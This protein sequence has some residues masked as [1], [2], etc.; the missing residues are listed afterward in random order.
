MPEKY[1]H[2]QNINICFVVP[3]AYPLIVSEKSIGQVGGAEVQQTIIAKELAK[4]GYNVSMVCLDY[5]QNDNLYIDGIRIVKAFR[6]DEGVPVLRY[7]YPRATSIWKAMKACSADIYYQRSA[8]ML[9]GLVALFCKRYKRYFLYAAAHDTDF[10]QGEE[11]IQYSR[12][13]LIYRWGLRYADAIIVQNETQRQLSQ[14]LIKKPIHLCRNLYPLPKEKKIPSEEGYILWVSTIREWKR[15]EL[16]LEIATRLPNLQFVMIGGPS[17][18]TSIFA[19]IQQAASRLSNVVFKGFIP[20]SEIGTYFDN[21]AI[22]LNTSIKE[23]FPNTFLQSWARRIPTISF[24][25]PFPETMPDKPGHYVANISEA[26]EKIATLMA[27]RG[28]RFK[29]GERCFEYFM[30]NHEVSKVISQ[31]DDIFNAV[32]GKRANRAY[33]H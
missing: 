13:C 33:S 2:S 11:L 28:T 17:R 1:K 10:I 32:M 26:V 27:D 18:N 3:T 20:Y 12:D 6:P 4:R 25:S 23:G 16:F 5:G 30:E 24:F 7:I 9:T 14:K 15:P 19:E 29:E 22:F 21:A 8:G 31:Y